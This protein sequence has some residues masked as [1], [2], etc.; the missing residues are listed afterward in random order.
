MTI[1]WGILG[2]FIIPD[3]P[4]ITRALWLT[5]EERVLAQ[6]RMKS[7][8]TDTARLI[9]WRRLKL[10]LY[11]TAKTPISYLFLVAYL[12]YAWSQRANSYFLLYLKV[13][14]HKTISSEKKY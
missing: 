1:F 2:L 6:E 10:K 5:K 12:Q 14:E 8:G 4:P 7:H 11:A 9:S 13:N 3:S